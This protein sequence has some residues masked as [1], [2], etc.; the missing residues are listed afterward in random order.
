[1]LK[2]YIVSY[3]HNYGTSAMFVN[4]LN[5]EEAIIFAKLEGAWDTAEAFEVDID[6]RGVTYKGD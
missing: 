5:A 3:D 1:M 4:A 2:H 6:F